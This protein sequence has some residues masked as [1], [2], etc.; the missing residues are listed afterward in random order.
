MSQFTDNQKR[1]WTLALDWYLHEQ[2]KSRTGVMLLSLGDNGCQLLSKL[3]TDMSLLVNVLWILCEEQAES[4]GVAAE[5]NLTAGDKFMKGLGGD[6]L[7]SAASALVEAV[8]DFFPN[9]VQR[10][11][12]RTVMSK[13]RETSEILTRSELEKVQAINPNTVAQNYIDLGGSRQP[14]PELATP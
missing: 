1:T 5:G 11:S 8:I 10:E 6:V 7:E 2:V 12:L 3:H 13:A 14:L 9:P 4:L